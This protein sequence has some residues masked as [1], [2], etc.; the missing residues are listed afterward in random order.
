VYDPAHTSTLPPLALG[1]VPAP[2][3]SAASYLVADID[4]GDVY[5]DRNAEEPQPIASLTKLMT[6]LVANETI[7]FNN[8]ISI[9][10]GALLGPGQ[11]STPEKRESF[12]V[13]DLLYPLLMQSN[14]AVADRL[15]QYYGTAGFVKWMNTTA[16]ALDMQSTHFADASGISAEDISTPDDI[17]RLATYLANKKSFIWD[18]TR[19]PTKRLVASSGDVYHFDNLNIFSGSPDFIG[20]K[21][22]QTVTAGKTMVSVFSMPVNGATRRIA[23]IVLKSADDTSDTTKLADWFT[24]SAKQG[25]LFAS[26]ACTSCATAPHYRKIQR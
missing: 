24:Q 18:I 22:G 10:S 5:V 19:T 16:K 14:N 20:G 25:A 23:V 13:G 17:Y 9:T 15:A 7:M 6:A 1:S 2:A 12:V 21:V 26:T 4:T 3:V 11:V 8:K